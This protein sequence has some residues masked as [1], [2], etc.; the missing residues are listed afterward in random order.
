MFEIS[1]KDSRLMY[2]ELPTSV[3]KYKTIFYPPK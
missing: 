1:D 2:K 3:P